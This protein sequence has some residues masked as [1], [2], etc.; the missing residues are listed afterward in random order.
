MKIITKTGHQASPRE[1][2]SQNQRIKTLRPLYNFAMTSG[3]TLNAHRLSI[4][5]STH[6]YTR[7]C[8]PALNLLLVC[9]G[10]ARRARFVTA[11]RRVRRHET[12]DEK[13]GSLVT[14]RQ[15][16]HNYAHAHPQR[17]LTP[18]ARPYH[19]RQERDPATPS[20][21]V[22]NCALCVLSCI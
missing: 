16:P 2:T 15:P 4:S 8:T 6:V 9:T 7:A 10:M 17:D 1:E 12:I 21:E 19:G 22:V 3:R 18:I 14:W 13:H 11:A 20:G 5:C